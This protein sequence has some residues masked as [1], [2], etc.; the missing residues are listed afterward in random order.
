MKVYT[1]FYKITENPDDVINSFN[2]KSMNNMNDEKYK[3][4]TELK[5][6]NIN[7]I[8]NSTEVYIDFK[9]TFNYISDINIEYINNLCSSISLTKTEAPLFIHN[10]AIDQPIPSAAAEIIIFLLLNF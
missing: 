3:E 7:D 10:S 6:F 2:N 4:K 5:W 8:E 9:N 1:Y